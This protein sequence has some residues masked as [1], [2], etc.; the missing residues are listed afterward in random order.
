MSW[1]KRSL[2]ELKGIHP[3]LRKVCDLSLDM[4]LK[5]GHDFMIIDGVRTREEQIKHYK[6]G[7]SKTMKS[8]HLH[9]LA[10]D[11][12][13]LVMGKG[14][15]ESVYFK[16]IGLVFKHAAI[17]LRIPITWGGDWKWKD[18]GHVELSKKAY[19]DP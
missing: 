4:A 17:Q 6:S 16:P 13:P 8:R 5:R 10:I 3:D 12:M 18:W 1:S 9:G 15:W 11:F 2:A 7:A 14:R 19:P